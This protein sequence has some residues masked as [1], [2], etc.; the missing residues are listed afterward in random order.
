MWGSGQCGLGGG[1]NLTSLKWLTVAMPLL[2]TIERLLRDYKETIKR[3]LR[4][5]SKRQY[6][7]WSYG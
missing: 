2:E 6:K 3:L 5:T 7:T 4:E 1:G